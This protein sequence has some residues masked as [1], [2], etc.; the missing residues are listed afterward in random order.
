[1]TETKAFITID[2]TDAVSPYDKVDNH[3]NRVRRK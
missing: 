1:M 2:N 3:P